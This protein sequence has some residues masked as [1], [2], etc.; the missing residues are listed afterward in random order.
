[1]GKVYFSVKL[2]VDCDEI[3]KKIEELQKLG[4]EIRRKASDLECLIGQMESE[5]KTGGIPPE[6]M[7]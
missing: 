6:K 1:M 7:N 5:E 3:L 2:G 4:T